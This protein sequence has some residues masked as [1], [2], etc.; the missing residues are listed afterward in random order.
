MNNLLITR[1]YPDSVIPNK[2]NEDAGYDVYAHFESTYL[3]ISPGTTHI[4]P[5]GIAT[6]FSSDYYAQI[7]ERGSTGSK[8]MSVR[9]GVFDSGFRGE[10][11]VMITNVNDKPLVISK[12]KPKETAIEIGTNN[13]IHYPYD[14]AIAQFVMLPV[15]KFNIV[16]VT[17][18]ELLEVESERGEGRLGSSGK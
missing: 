13:F 14:K 1:L 15:P 5:T 2:K 3:V 10:W 4:I 18:E 12:L 17:M 6:A 7:E 16:E 9:A 8:G 11:C